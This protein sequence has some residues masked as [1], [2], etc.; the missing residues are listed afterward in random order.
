MVGGGWGGGGGGGMIICQSE[1]V[2]CV[3]VHVCF[4]LSTSRSASAFVYILRSHTTLS[5]QRQYK[6]TDLNQTENTVTQ[7]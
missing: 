2:L 6:A 1:E 3:C 7:F 5:L 4:V